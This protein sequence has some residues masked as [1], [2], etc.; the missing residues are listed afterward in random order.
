MKGTGE[1]ISEIREF[2]EFNSLMLYDL[3]DYTLIQDSTNKVV[4]HCGENLMNFVKTELDN[5]VLSIKD[6]NSCRW[7]RSLPVKI[8][9][10]IHYTELPYIQNQSSGTLR[11]Q[12]ALRQDVFEFKNIDSASKNYL[13]I[14]GQEVYLKLQS[15]SPLLEVTGYS[16]ITYFW[17]SGGGKL[18]AEEFLSYAA[19][20]DNKAQG[21]IRC[22]VNGG[23]LWYLID[24]YG[25]TYYRG[26][27]LEIIEVSRTGTGELIALD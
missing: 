7:L 2:S 24:G 14:E 26:E 19:W 12:G 15:G 13:E 23:P 16:D 3:I 10:D 22:A 6:E 20:A 11:T 1:S 17:N 21:E 27:T 9:V 8:S 4:I 18:H 25:N 5:G